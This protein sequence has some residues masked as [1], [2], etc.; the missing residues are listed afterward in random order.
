YAMDLTPFKDE[1]ITLNGTGNVN[2]PNCGVYDN[3][4][5]LTHGASGAIT[6][7]SIAVVGEYS[8]GAASPTPI[9]GVVPVPDPMGYW[10]TPAPYGGACLSD[11]KLT[12]GK[13]TPGCYKGL[14]VT[15]PAGLSA[16]L[17]IIQGTLK[18]NGVTASGVTFYIDG[19]NGGSFGSVD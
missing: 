19:A 1:G 16:G 14:T 12:T 7:K 2:V 3:S 6:A 10:S 15:S 4:G 17:Y 13:A 5:L 9:T 18:L 8:G 11:P